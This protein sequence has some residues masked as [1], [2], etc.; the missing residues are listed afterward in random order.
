MADST[1]KLVIGGIGPNFDRLVAARDIETSSILHVA[2]ELL[3][4]VHAAMADPAFDGED[5][6]RHDAAVRVI[7]ETL[8]SLCDVRRSQLRSPDCPH[9]QLKLAIERRTAT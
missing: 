4:A 2:A 3:R 9:R 5:W 6:L 7:A 8:A 1:P